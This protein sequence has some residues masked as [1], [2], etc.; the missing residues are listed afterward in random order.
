MKRTWYVG[1]TNASPTGKEAFPT[2]VRP[3]PE[4]TPQYGAVWG[5][6]RTRRAAE[7]AASQV[8][9]PHIV[10]VSDAE[11]ICRSGE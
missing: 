9:N 5:P 7:F 2:T 6:F 3:S 11:R 8:G 10:T 4:A 1:Y